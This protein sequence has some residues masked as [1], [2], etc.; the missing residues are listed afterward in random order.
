MSK[1][2]KVIK[3]NSDYEIVI[4]TGSNYGV[5]EEDIFLIYRL[6]EELFDPETNKSLGKL[7]LICGRGKV[8]HIQAELTTLTSCSKETKIKTTIVKKHGN[9]FFGNTEEETKIPT[10]ET[11]PFDKVGTDCFARLLR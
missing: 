1:D 4:A 8:K 11:L 6:G 10:T 5:K 9:Y 7:E 2:A 3:V